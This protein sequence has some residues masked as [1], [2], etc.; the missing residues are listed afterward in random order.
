[1]G[2]LLR[3]DAREPYSETNTV[4]V[5]RIQWLAIELARC[6]DGCNECVR[7][8]ERAGPVGCANLGN[9]PD[10]SAGVPVSGSACRN[11][12]GCDVSAPVRA[13]VRDGKCDDVG[14]GKEGAGSPGEDEQMDREIARTERW[15]QSMLRER[16][17]AEGAALDSSTGAPSDG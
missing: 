7:E 14:E 8:R 11:G 3:V 15:L 1:M 16:P 5:P 4:L 12:G 2:T 10:T 13:K 9:L 6:R 17:P